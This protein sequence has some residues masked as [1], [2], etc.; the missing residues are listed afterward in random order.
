MDTSAAC[1]DDLLCSGAR[2]LTGHQRRLFLAE[3]ATELCDGSAAKPNDV[4]AGGARRSRKGCMR[5]VRACGVWRISP[6]E[7]GLAAKTRTTIGER[8][9]GD[10][11]TPFARRSGTEV[12]TSVHEPV[13]S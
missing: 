3:V 11:G 10:R 1:V 9:P 13:G 5:P 4:L 12:V 7:A 6:R 8:Y 2:R